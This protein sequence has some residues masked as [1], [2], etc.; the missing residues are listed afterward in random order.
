MRLS[1]APGER[2]YLGTDLGAHMAA[3]A[4]TAGK[5]AQAIKSMAVHAFSVR[6]LSSFFS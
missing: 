6:P 2:E 3:I 1:A 4:I 5:S